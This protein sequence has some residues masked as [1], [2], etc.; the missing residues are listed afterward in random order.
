MWSYPGVRIR[1]SIGTTIRSAVIVATV[2]TST[3]VTTQ[4][5]GYP[6]RVLRTPFIDHLLRGNALTSL[7]RAIKN[8]VRFQR[9]LGT[10]WA[11]LLREALS[12]KRSQELTWSQVVMAANTPMLLKASMVEGNVA[13]GVMAGGQV[14]GVIDEL[15]SC[16]ELISRIVAQAAQVLEGFEAGEI[17]REARSR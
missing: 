7:P 4:V 10:S 11:D 2:V 16:A 17:S 5:D 1:S 14:T 6:H 15:P 13:S 8:A 12:M 9:M 3:V